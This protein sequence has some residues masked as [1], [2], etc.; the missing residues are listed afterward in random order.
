[1]EKMKKL[2]SNGFTVVDFFCGGGIGAVGT[3]Y[4]GFDTIFAFD[5]N[6]H[7][8][9]SYNE[10]LKHKVAVVLDAKTITSKDIPYADFYTGG[11]PCQPFSIAGKNLGVNDPDKGNLGLVITQCILDNEPKGFMLEN[12]GGL[13]NKRNIQFLEEL[14]ELL[15]EKYNVTWE[16]INCLD[17]GVPQERV[18]I[19]IMGVHKK[20]N[21]KF[22][23]PEK[24]KEIYTVRDAIGDLPKIPDNK[25]NH[26]DLEK[27]K[28]RNDE[29]PYAH[30]IPVGKNWKSLPIEDQKAFMKKAFYSGGGRTG[31]LRKIDPDKPSKT[32]MSTV[33]GK[34]TALILDW[35]V[36]DQRRYTVRESLRLQTVPDHYVFPEDISPAKKYERCSGIPSLVSYKF[37]LQLK[38]CVENK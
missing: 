24:T 34:A 38:K 10:N 14:V 30:K 16:K 4:A 1:M 6:K 20:F 3:E 7:A 21:S 9:R 31:F 15:S 22:E 29:K 33:M 32:I 11:F 13:S 26:D 25:N 17:Y 35:G 18:R 23:F 2:K 28:L 5:N 12:V 19:F 27:F 37:M 36:N 8:V